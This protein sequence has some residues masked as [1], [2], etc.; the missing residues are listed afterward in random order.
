[1]KQ[2]VSRGLTSPGRAS[3]PESFT[4][5]RVKRKTDAKSTSPPPK[6][7]F[8]LRSKSNTFPQKTPTTPIYNGF[9]NLKPL[10]SRLAHH[11][12]S[13]SLGN[14]LRRNKRRLFLPISDYTIMATMPAKQ[15][16]PSRRY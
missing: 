8:R 11:C 15:D 4:S 1:M 12:V 10:H 9:R 14:R 6:L 3:L 2:S 16:T 7:F 13:I 5:Q